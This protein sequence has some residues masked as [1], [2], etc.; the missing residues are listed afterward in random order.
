MNYRFPAENLSDDDDYI[1]VHAITPKQPIERQADINDNQNR[2]QGHD[3]PD[4]EMRKTQDHFETVTKRT[5]LCNAMLMQKKL[6]YRFCIYKKG[7]QIFIDLVALNENGK[8]KDILRKNITNED[9]DKLIDD[10]S[11]IEGLFVDR[12]A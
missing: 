11:S 3:H 10:I 8:I 9:F 5:E 12:E 4:H 7:R 1:R 6:P 2:R